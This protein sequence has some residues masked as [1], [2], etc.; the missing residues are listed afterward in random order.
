MSGVSTPSF[1]LSGTTTL[2]AAAQAAEGLLMQFGPDARAG[3][4]AE[5]PDALAAEAER[6]HEQTCAPVLAGLRIA[7][8]GAGTVIDLRFFARRG[9]DDARTLPAIEFRAV[10]GRSA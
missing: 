2:V 9:L 10:C 5:K 3:M 6:Q 4:E 1:R 8:H 7:D